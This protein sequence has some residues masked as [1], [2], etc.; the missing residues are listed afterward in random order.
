V[1]NV[2]EH[3]GCGVDDIDGLIAVD[4]GHSRA[5]HKLHQSAS[6]SQPDDAT[7][8][9]DPQLAESRQHLSRVS[10]SEQTYRRG[11]HMLP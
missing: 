2:L 4:H 6:P 5:S 1:A 8:T 7:R 3:L 10:A 11:T 9:S